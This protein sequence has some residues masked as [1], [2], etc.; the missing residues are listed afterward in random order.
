MGVPRFEPT[1]LTKTA[2][3]AART[4]LAVTLGWFKENAYPRKTR[5]RARHLL[6]YGVSPVL[7]VLDVDMRIPA[8]RV[9]APRSVFPAPSLDPDDMCPS[10]VIVMFE[11]TWRW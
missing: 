4:K 11:R 7:V 2:E 1:K 10:D 3:D 6:G 5:R 9:F 8:W